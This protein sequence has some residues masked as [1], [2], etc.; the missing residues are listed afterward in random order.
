MNKKI[1]LF[2]PLLCA[3]L[4]G[5]SI[6]SPVSEPV[7]ESETVRESESTKEPETET[8]AA[9]PSTEETAEPPTIEEFPGSVENP[10]VKP[11]KPGFD[12]GCRILLA[13]DI[14]YL[15]KNLTDFGE[16]F[17]YK[18]EHGDGKLVNYIWEITDAFIGAVKTENPD[19]VI[20]SGDLTLNGEKESHLEFAEKLQEIE[21]AG[22][23]V[24]VIP[25]NHDI[26]NT[27]AAQ[28][29]AEQALGTP[30]ISPEEF[31]G[32]YQEYGYNEAVSRDP[33]S[34]SYEIGRAHV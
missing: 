9:I 26:N 23:P 33:A 1:L 17:T 16:A 22:V 15:S 8:P 31:A 3:A 11:P 29:T 24:I 13:S 27:S 2:V 18:V 4:V 19:L 20:L 21:D 7:T 34:L 12:E 30:H 14:H 10:V 6:K 25:G 32:I 28:F 5:C